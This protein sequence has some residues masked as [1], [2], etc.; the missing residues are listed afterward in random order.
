MVGS[1]ARCQERDEICRNKDG[2]HASAFPFCLPL[3]QVVHL[4]NWAFHFLQ[5]V[6]SP[7]LWIFGSSP[8]PLFHGGLAWQQGPKAVVLVSAHMTFQLCNRL[9][10]FFIDCRSWWGGECT[11]RAASQQKKTSVY[12]YI[13]GIYWNCFFGKKSFTGR[14]RRCFKDVFLCCIF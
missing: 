10:N 8:W 13:C 12:Q 9:F 4:I 7:I 11:V 2:N 14:S 1:H 3:L 5:S 6:V